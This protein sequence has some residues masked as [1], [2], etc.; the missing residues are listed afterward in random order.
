[1]A[2]VD[3]QTLQAQI[4]EL[5][6]QVALAQADW[7]E[8]IAGQDVPTAPTLFGDGGAQV[9]PTADKA[10]KAWRRLGAL[11]RT[12]HAR[13]QALAYLRAH[14]NTDLTDW[15]ERLARD[16]A[17]VQRAT[18]R[19]EQTRVE[20]TAAYQRREQAQARGVKIPG[21][22]PVPVEEHARV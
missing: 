12:L 7:D 15:R 20:V 1:G 5:Q 14:P 17:R 9:G 11:T 8:Q 2:T 4:A 6:R 21:T 19:L 13:E 16:Q 3:E 10:G 22:R 18:E